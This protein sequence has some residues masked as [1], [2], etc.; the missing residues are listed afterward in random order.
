MS[1]K[2]SLKVINGMQ[3]ADVWDDINR[4]YGDRIPKVLGSDDGQQVNIPSFKA[5]LFLD[6]QVREIL[7][8]SDGYYKSKSEIVRIC[9]TIGMK[10]LYPKWF[11]DDGKLI[12]DNM[13]E[14]CKENQIYEAR[15]QYLN[16]AREQ[17]NKAQR[18]WSEG[19]L[20]DNELQKI[21]KGILD[22][23]PDE[24]T[25]AVV[26]KIFHEDII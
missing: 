5:S 7:D 25:R 21:L 15:K 12:R 8:R 23:C 2:T 10:L 11:S 19:L 16:M 17:R 18:A 6:R 20:S 24:Q 22:N 4:D 1:D 9:A 3:Q 13:Y 26:E 14:M